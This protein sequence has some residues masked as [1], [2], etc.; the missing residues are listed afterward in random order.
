[1]ARIEDLGLSDEAI[2][3]ALAFD[4]LPPQDSNFERLWEWGDDPNW[5]GRPPTGVTG[6]PGASLPVPSSGRIH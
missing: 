5:T 3:A 1:M 4:E 2:G 6:E